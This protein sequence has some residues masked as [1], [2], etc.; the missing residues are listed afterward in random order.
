MSATGIS[1]PA[2]GRIFFD[3]SPFIYYIEENVSYLETLTSLFK[4]NDAGEFQIVTSSLTLTEVLILPLRQQANFIVS[5][6][7]QILL[8]SPFIFVAP[9]NT[10][11]AKRAAEIRALYNFRTPDAL[12]LATAIETSADVFLT[13]DHQLSIIKEIEVVI[14]K[15]IHE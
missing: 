4:R 12:Q 8:H 11:I 10:A 13:N 7:E 2:G 5:E 9:I 15:D 3:T 1:I 14:L 6:Y